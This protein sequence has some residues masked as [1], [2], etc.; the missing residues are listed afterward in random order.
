MEIASK[1]D[2]YARSG[3]IS[4]GHYKTKISYL[5]YFFF[6]NLLFIDYYRNLNGPKEHYDYMVITALAIFSQS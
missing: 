1:R 4:K 2:T 6:S 5:I 3:L